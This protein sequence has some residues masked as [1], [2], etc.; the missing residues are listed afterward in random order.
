MAKEKKIKQGAQIVT[1]EGFY[2]PVELRKNPRK[3][4]KEY[5]R[6]VTGTIDGEE[7][8]LNYCSPVYA[9][10]KNEEIFPEIEKVLNDNG[11]KFEVT[12][13]HINNVRFYADYTITDDRYAYQMK[14]TNDKIRPMLRVQHS[15]NGLTKYKI[16]FGYF[17]LVC[18]NGLTV[19]VQEM[20]EF[21]LC[22]VGK[23]TDSIK[24]S[25]KKLNAM[26]EHFAENAVQINLAITA[27]YEALGGSWVKNP[28]ERLAEVLEAT[29]IAMVDNKNFNT[30]NDIMSRINHEAQIPNLGY[31]GRVNDWLIYN[32]INQYL[33][34]DNRNIAVPEKRQE[35]DS[36]V[37]EYLLETA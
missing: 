17:R 5:S 28:V 15:Y 2:F 23:H 36:K 9:L 13:R 14:G 4:N 21:N 29:K 27:R 33:N 24:Q 22:I 34:D 19:P 16:T 8:D 11:I 30:L 18:T 20:K 32:G 37:L 12:Y 31:K 1:A 35:T 6:V 26:M 25:F 3:T 7:V 10:V